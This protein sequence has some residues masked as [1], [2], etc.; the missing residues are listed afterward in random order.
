[1][2]SSRRPFHRDLLTASQHLL[3]NPS[4]DLFDL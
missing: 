2:A 1:M 4:I 3:N